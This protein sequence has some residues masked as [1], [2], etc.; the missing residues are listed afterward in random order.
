MRRLVQLVA[1]LF[2]MTVPAFGA[3]TIT[4]VLVTNMT[5][6]TVTIQ[7]TT[8]TPS[9]SMVMYGTDPSL[10][11]S[12]NAVATPVTNHTVTLQLLVVGPFY[13]AAAVSTDNSGTTQSS[14]VTWTMCGSPLTP[15]NGTATNYYAYGTYSMVWQP[16]AGY[17]QAPTVCGQSFPTTIAGSLDGG[18]SFN[19]NVADASKI[20]PGP[21]QWQV[22]V[23]D[24][25]NIAPITISAYLSQVTQNISVPLQAA[26]KASG[27]QT[28]LTN[29]LTS[30]SWPPS[31]GSGGGGGGGCSQCAYLNVANTFS[32]TNTFPAITVNGGINGLP[33]YENIGLFNISMGV[34][35]IPRTATGSQNF[36][37]A[38]Q[39][40][41]SLTSGFGNGG[42]GVGAL[43]ALTTG[44]EF[45]CVGDECGA[46]ATTSY[47]SAGLGAGALFGLTT[48]DNDTGMGA[49]A[50]SDIQASSGVVCVGYLAGSSNVGTYSNLPS[51][52]FIGANTLPQANGDTNEEVVGNGATG[53]GSNTQTI[54]N[55]S[56]TSTWIYGVPTFPSLGG[57]GS[58]CIGVSNTGLTSTVSCGSGGGSS[59]FQVNGVALIS[60]A[61]VNFQNGSNVTITNPSA[62]NVSF[63]VT[64]LPY[65]ALTGTV[66]TWNQSTTGQAGTALALAAT[67]T[68][69]SSGSAPTGI[70]A[71][72]NVNGCQSISPATGPTL[73]TNGTNNTSGTLL[74]FV[75]T[76][77]IAFTNPSGGIES[78]AIVSPGNSTLLGF[79]SGGTY[80]GFSLGTNLAFSGSVLNAT[81][82]S[83]T[84]TANCIPKATGASSLACSSIT[85]SG[86]LVSISEPVSLTS[87][88]PGVWDL[89]AGTGSL[90]AAPA[91][92]YGFIGPV[93]GGTPYDLQNPNAPSS[94][95]G[96]LEYA[97]PTTVNNRNVTTA[98]WFHPEF[99]VT[100][101]VGFFGGN[102]L[103]A[104]LF[105][106]VAINSGRFINISAN[107]LTSGS[108][109]T[110]PP[111]VAA[112]AANSYSTFI[113]P[114]TS[115]TY[116]NNPVVVTFG[117]PLAITAGQNYGLVIEVAGSGC[118]TAQFSFTAMVEEP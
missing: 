78:A 19:T 39:T 67:P 99:P 58:G 84:L 96:L 3:P 86:T 26:A 15:V 32:Q 73:Q 116:Q 11:Y 68:Q 93:T 18:S 103:Y 76:S 88:L 52:M 82:I 13:Y 54:G 83:G 62:G 16:P 85:D 81:G 12:T 90:T 47:K 61:T 106:G 98:T 4:N 49:G 2:L 25:G 102:A 74:N 41:S 77:T 118:A 60:T 79:N 34:G 43:N 51:G 89:A 70:A 14:P 72:G 75:S 57:A 87:S 22:T 111:Q 117:T 110:T 94:T 23:T 35:S 55:P 1:C 20:V 66:P 105:S 9:S 113:T 7:W 28:C 80:T 92:S 63:A 53:H 112:F 97:A 8:T 6:T 114:S 31:C 27:L 33:L 36:G 59:A 100:S 104:V 10:P 101:G 48:G 91:N 69:C 108:G 37:I 46:N 45:I 109:C 30:D 71:N 5:A 50:C 115:E 44:F 38:D 40:L 95:G 65:S 29:T 42:I 24:A 64:S 56:M 107:T 21:G 17:S